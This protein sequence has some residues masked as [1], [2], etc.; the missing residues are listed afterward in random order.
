MTPPTIQT[1]RTFH[2][3]YTSRDM[4]LATRNTA[5]PIIDPTRTAVAAHRP[6]PRMSPS[7]F[8]ASDVCVPMNCHREFGCVV[9]RAPFCARARVT[10][11]AEGIL[12]HTT[13]TLLPACRLLPAN[14]LSHSPKRPQSASRFLCQ[15]DFLPRGRCRSDLC[16]DASLVLA[17][18][19]DGNLEPHSSRNSD[20]VFRCEIG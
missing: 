15:S 19:P 14:P 12:V 4:S 10:G 2:I 6:R 18:C 3:E 8:P 16:G 9:R 20:D 17:S 13:S 1:T 11:Y 7:G 5:C